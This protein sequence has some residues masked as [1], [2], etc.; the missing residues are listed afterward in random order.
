[1]EHKIDAKGKSMGR[2]AT[3]IA[4]LLLGKSTPAT[5][6]RNAVITDKVRVLNVNEIAVDAKRMVQK[7]YHSHSGYPGGDRHRTLREVIEKKGMKN[8][9][10]RAVNGMLP[11]N[12]LRE[13]RLKQLVI[14][15]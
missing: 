13:K 2:I 5:F 12:T 14:E 1:M 3:E 10:V 4:E 8:A 9:L 6:K 11:K 7:T 15:D